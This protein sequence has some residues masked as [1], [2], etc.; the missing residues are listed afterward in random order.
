MTHEVPRNRPGV[1]NTTHEFGA[2]HVFVYYDNRREEN[3]LETGKVAVV[4]Y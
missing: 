2:I 3:K 4:V 1:N